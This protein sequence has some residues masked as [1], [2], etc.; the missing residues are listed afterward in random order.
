MFINKISKKIIN[1]K[2]KLSPL[3]I[4]L[5]KDIIMRLEKCQI[6]N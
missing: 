5:L 6:F 1:I 2:I 3:I 4:V